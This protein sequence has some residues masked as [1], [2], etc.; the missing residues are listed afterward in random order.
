MRVPFG[1]RY[2]RL[3]FGYGYLWWIWDGPFS[4][5]PYEGAYTGQG[6]VGQFITVLP[7]LDLVVAH[8]TV[9][10]DKRNVSGAQYRELLDL[11][12]SARGCGQ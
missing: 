3:P 1:R 9:P 7:K 5:G 10:G 4:A 2:R 11:L 12:V 6:A 8:K